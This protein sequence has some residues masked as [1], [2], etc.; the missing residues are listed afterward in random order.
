MKT[1]LLAARPVARQHR[2]AGCSRFGQAAPCRL[3]HSSA[4]AWRATARA[5]TPPRWVV[6]PRDHYPTPRRCPRAPTRG[7]VQVIQH[8]GKSII[9]SVPCGLGGNLKDD[10]IHALVG[11]LRELCC[12]KTERRRGCPRRCRAGRMPF[13]LPARPFPNAT[14]YH[15][16]EQTRLAGLCLAFARAPAR[17]PNY[18]VR[19]DHRRGRPAGRAGT[20]RLR[21]GPSNGQVPGPLIHVKEGDQ[22]EVLLHN[23]TTL[24]HTSTG[25]G[26]T[27]PTAG[28]PTACPT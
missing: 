1:L 12:Q 27:R 26:F 19:D 8:G 9:K 6:Q 20:W 23:N 7:A 3:L 28:S 10:E 13:R 2:R 25:I 14:E 21:S 24:S 4:T 18:E 11:Y 17:R 5:S 22:V 16:D 15:H